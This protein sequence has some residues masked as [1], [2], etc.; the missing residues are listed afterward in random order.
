MGTLA[1]ELRNPK[2]RIFINPVG[3]TKKDIGVFILDSF[4][5]SVKNEG[6]MFFK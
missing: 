6:L 2:W 1:L 3:S 4:R 5:L